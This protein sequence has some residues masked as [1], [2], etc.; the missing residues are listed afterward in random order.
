MRQL[1]PA[2]HKICGFDFNSQINI[3]NFSPFYN[4]KNCKRY[5]L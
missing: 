4:C 3:D 1:S 5:H 2:M